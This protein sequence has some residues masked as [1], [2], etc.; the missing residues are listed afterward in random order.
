M[1]AAMLML[2]V[3]LLG[4]ILAS[5]WLVLYQLI[6][7]QGR[8]LLRQDHLEQQLAGGSPSAAV[9]PAPPPGLAVGTP[10][11]PF[12]LPDLNGKPVALE[13]FRGQKLLLVHWNPQCGFCDL[14]A[15]DLA[16]LQAD[17]KKRQVRLVLLAHGGTSANRKLAQKYGLE[18]PVLLI[19]PK[20]PIKLFE[21][22]GTPAAY[23]VDEEGKVAQ[24]L[25][26]GADRV[27][28]LAQEAA[29]PPGRRKRLPGE[30]YLSTSHI[31][32]HGLKPGTPAP[33]FRLPDLDGRPVA[34]GDYRGR[35]VLLVL[36]DP[37]CGPCEELAPRLVDIHQRHRDNGLAVLMVGRGDPEAN[38]RKAREHGFPFPVVVQRSWE[39]SKQYGI[40]ATPVAYLIDE[41][42]VISRAVAQGVEAIQA[43]VPEPEPVPA[44]VS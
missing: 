1:I 20:E 21:T 3:V 38:R 39:I 10:I 14:I 31:E 24:P 13:D 41:Q 17:L 42:G 27:P 40:F 12:R 2:V 37:N 25:A 26:V 28:A 43:L 19:K 4:L 8:L 6:K 32:R 16:R 5:L 30:R 15:P 7:Q 22:L 35:K 36:S 29:S 33:A 23:L 11:E 44:Q 18:A 34:L 9:A